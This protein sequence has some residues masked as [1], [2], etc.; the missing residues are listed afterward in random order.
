M[1]ARSRPLNSLLALVAFAAA[2]ATAVA[3]TPANQA[4]LSLDV[5]PAFNVAV[6]F[7]HMSWN[8]RALSGAD[9]ISLVASHQLARFVRLACD[10]ATLSGNTV[11]GSGVEAARHYLVHAEL[12]VAPE[13]SVEGHLVHPQLGAGIGTVVSDPAA[14]SSSTRSQNAWEILAG[15]DVDVVGPLTAGVQYHRVATS[16]QD[17]AAQG[18]QSTGSAVRAHLIEARIGVRF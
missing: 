3:Q 6:G 2:P 9:G 7:A 1:R 8:D 12:S 17:V 4:P 14:D 11:S 15:V 10:F 16:L 18:P 5:H 13:I